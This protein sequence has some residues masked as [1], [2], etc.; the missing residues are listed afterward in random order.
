MG[1]FTDRAYFC[2]G[3]KAVVK[4]ARAAI[5]RYQ[6][7]NAEYSGNGNCDFGGPVEVAADELS[8]KYWCYTTG[9]VEG[10]TNSLARLS[11]WSGL[12][13]A[14]YIGCTDGV[15][16]GMLF[17]VESGKTIARHE[18]CADIGLRAAMAVAKLGEKKDA[19]AFAALIE[20]Y[21]ESTDG[22]VVSSFAENALADENFESNGDDTEW[23][24]DAVIAGHIGQSLS[25]YP[26]LLAPQST[27]KALLK[28]HRSFVHTKAWMSKLD[29]CGASTNQHVDGLIAHLERLE[30]GEAAKS[31]SA[32]PQRHRTARKAVRI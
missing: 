2:K 31:S 3:D 29:L 13:V 27:Q 20:S 7:K 1:T 22:G 10:L 23:Q 30:I 26:E 28:L 6:I 19:A 14:H 15:N 9:S 4:K 5:E 12:Y 17:A 25:V 8:L 18:F 21:S 24:Q 16:M 11:K 32:Q